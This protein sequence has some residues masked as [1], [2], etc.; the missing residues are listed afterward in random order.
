M[1]SLCHMTSSRMVF[2]RMQAPEFLIH[3]PQA[4]YVSVHGRGTR[5]QC[6]TLSLFRRQLFALF[7]TDAHGQFVRFAITLQFV[8]NLWHHESVNTA[9]NSWDH[10]K[11]NLLFRSW[12]SS[13]LPGDQ[14]AALTV[15]L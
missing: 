3:S 11:S 12:T 9:A 10:L 5:R 15:L 8:K 2:S 4:M 1:V 14:I 13:P 7:F 6:E